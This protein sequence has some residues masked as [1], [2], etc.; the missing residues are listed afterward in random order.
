LPNLNPKISES[1]IRRTI[2]IVLLYL[3]LPIQALSPVKDLDI[4]WHLRTGEWIVANLAVPYQDY[5][6]TYGNGKPWIAYS[7]LFEVCVYAVHTRFGLTGLVYFTVVMAILITFVVHQLVRLARLPLVMEVALSGLALTA[8]S[9][10]MSPRPWLFTILFF[11]IELILISRAREEGK[12]QLLRFMPLIFIF[13]ANLH[14]QFVYGLIVL[15]LLLVESALAAGFGRYKL[16]SAGKRLSPRLV[17]SVAT[18]SVLATLVS[19]YHVFIFNPI[20]EYVSQ[21]G[22]FQNISELHPMFFRSPGD[23]IVLSLTLAAVFALGWQR[24]WSLF[25]SLL[26]ILGVF[27][28]FRAKR[29]AWFIVLT[30]I[31]IIGHHLRLHWPGK[32]YAFTTG[33]ISTVA[34]L[35]ASALLFFS[36]HRQINERNLQSIVAKEFPVDAV[37]YVT[38]NRLRGPIFNTLDWGGFLIWGLR[39]LPVTIDGRTNLHGDQRLQALFDVWLGR[40]GWDSN[41]E[42]RSANIIIA[43]HG[44]P[45]TWLL[46]S[47]SRYTIAYEDRTALVFT[48]AR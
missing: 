17:M 14:I 11:S 38:R 42:F 32:P 16:P 48:S 12:D 20:W 39:E 22:A 43:D 47:D 25:P 37:A 10:L 19:P 36:I 15:G 33:Q 23:W 7:W 6:S 21:T 24:K 41:P 27:L 9:P 5:F 34:V 31:G 1:S 40:P 30:A 26:L 3:I 2:L 44:R 4:W 29:D 13:W 18:A 46:R 35:V 28:G 8:M 45:L